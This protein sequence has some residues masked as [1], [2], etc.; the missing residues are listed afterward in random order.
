MTE[1]QILMLNNL[2][3]DPIFSSEGAEAFSVGELLAFIDTDVYKK[4]G[5]LFGPATTKEEWDN[6]IQLAAE[7]EQLCRLRITERKND[8]QTGAKAICFYDE[9]KDEAVVV[10]AGTGYNEWRDNF[11]AGTQ[12][13]TKQQIDA[14]EWFE[15]LNYE[16]ITVSGHSKGGNK[17]MYIAVC[18]EKE[19]E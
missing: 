1:I 19:V 4:Q 15:T 11:T 10:F 9:Q 7:D 12:T 14:L 2:I 16:N 3:Y 8:L 13:D 6:L 5:N 17:A 18:S